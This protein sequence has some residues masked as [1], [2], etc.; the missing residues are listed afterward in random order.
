MKKVPAVERGPMIEAQ[1]KCLFA[2]N[3]N[4]RFDQDQTTGSALQEGLSTASGSCKS[5]LSSSYHEEVR[6]NKKQRPQV[7]EAL[8]DTFL[9]CC[10]YRST[11]FQM[12]DEKKIKTSGSARRFGPQHSNVAGTGT[13]FELQLQR[14]D[15]R[16]GLLKR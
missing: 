15:D 14:R 8:N 12:T 13:I 16:S 5:T 6:R 1:S 3:E 9:A 10:F 7:A 4:T 11:F 2:Q